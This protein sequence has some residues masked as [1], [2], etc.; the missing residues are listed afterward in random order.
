MGGVLAEPDPLALC[1][2]IEGLL[3]DLLVRA[4]RSRDGAELVAERTWPNAAEQVER[5]LRAALSVSTG[6]GDLPTA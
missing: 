6:V 1:D 3:D 2:A 4:T 5:G